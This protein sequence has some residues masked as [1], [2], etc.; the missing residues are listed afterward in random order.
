M[1]IINFTHQMNSSNECHTMSLKIKILYDNF[2]LAIQT[3]QWLI[4]NEEKGGGKM[5]ENLQK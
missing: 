5:A 4:E 1:L 2:I 3:T